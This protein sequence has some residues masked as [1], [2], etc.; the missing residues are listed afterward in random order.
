[1]PTHIRSLE[2]TSLEFASW[3]GN[4]SEFSCWLHILILMFNLFTVLSLLMSH[5]IE[6]QIESPDIETSNHEHRRRRTRRDNHD[7]YHVIIFTPKDFKCQKIPAS[8]RGTEEYL[9]IVKT[10]RPSRHLNQFTQVEI[11]ETLDSLIKSF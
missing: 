5:E 11:F 4:L 10:F 8:S 7:F 3:G 6:L 9:V 1:M 2:M